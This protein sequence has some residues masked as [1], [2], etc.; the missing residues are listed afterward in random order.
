MSVEVND[1]L[2]VLI[3]AHDK[4]IKSSEL[5]KAVLKRDPKASLPIS[6]TICSTIMAPH[7]FPK[8]DLVFARVIRK[9]GNTLINVAM[10]IQTTADGGIVTKYDYRK[11]WKDYENND[12]KEFHAFSQQWIKLCAAVNRTSG[13]YQVVAN[14]FLVE[15][16]ILPQDILTAMPIDL[17]KKIVLGSTGIYVD[18]SANMVTNLNIFSTAHT[19]D[20]MRQKTGGEDC[21]DDGDYLAWSEMEW[22]LYGQTVIDTVD[23]GE[24]CHGEPS[25]IVYPASMG[26]ST[27]LQLCESLGSKVPSIVTTGD[28]AN[29]KKYLEPFDDDFVI[30][31]AIDDKEIEGQWR[32]YYTR[33]LMNHSEAWLPGGPNRGRDEN[34]AFLNNR[35]KGGLIQLDD[36]H[37]D[38]DHWC[39]CENNPESFLRLRGLCKGSAIETHYRPKGSLF[40]LKQFRIIGLHSNIEHNGLS[41]L[42]ELSV[43]ESKVRAISR[44]SLGSFTLG[45]HNWTILMDKECNLNG[46]SDSYTVE[47]KM[48]GCKDGQFIGLFDT[49]KTKFV[50]F[51]FTKT[52]NYPE[53]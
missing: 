39:M 32:D 15:N 6:F 8:H 29:V 1:G 47:L 5:S 40:D 23:D 33:Q 16:R 12:T 9:D 41:G 25:S 13:L 2:K 34:C 28:W 22:T 17:S 24:A 18:P 37:C 52:I 36:D 45:K 50:H 43:A 20:D 51:F 4:S 14:G 38:L 10:Q 49:K 44:A 31:T 19:L 53:L 30:W 11:Q 35:G 7:V 48:S 21:I 46:K 26:Q 27:C 42:W 3:L